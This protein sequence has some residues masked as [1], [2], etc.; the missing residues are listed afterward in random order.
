MRIRFVLVKRD[1]RS[2]ESGV[3]KAKRES[4]RQFFVLLEAMGHPKSK[5]NRNPAF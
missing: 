5:T 1:S 3:K 4:D 2:F